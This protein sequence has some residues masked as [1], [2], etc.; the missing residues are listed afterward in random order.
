MFVARRNGGHPFS[1]STLG[2]TFLAGYGR[3]C[4]TERGHRC[5]YAWQL[6]R[7]EYL[8]ASVFVGIRVCERCCWFKHFCYECVHL[9]RHNCEGCTLYR[10][11]RFTAFEKHLHVLHALFNSLSMK[12][13]KS[14]YCSVIKY[15]LFLGSY[16]SLSSAYHCI[17]TS[18]YKES[19]HFTRE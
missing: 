10:R 13:I 8:W 5:F 19:L 14:V 11:F 7:K 12:P 3:K 16:S 1:L 18:F 17:F 2:N 4:L 15:M 6:A 9:W